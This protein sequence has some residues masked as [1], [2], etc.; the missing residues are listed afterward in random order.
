MR[1]VILSIVANIITA[2]FLVY[3]SRL[4]KII[5][6]KWDSL[7][8]YLISCLL[9]LCAAALLFFPFYNIYDL[10]NHAAFD[11]SFVLKVCINV[12]GIILQISMFFFGFIIARLKN[13]K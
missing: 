13:I 10:Y 1:D 4:F 2:I 5:I 7:K 3:W 11:K 9:I 12:S 6:R 8:E